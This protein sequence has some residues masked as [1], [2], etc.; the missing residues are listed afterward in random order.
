MISNLNRLTASFKTLGEYPKDAVMSATTD[1]VLG[2]GLTTPTKKTHHHGLTGSYRATTVGRTLIVN[3]RRN[4]HIDWEAFKHTLDV[5]LAHHMAYQF[6]HD[7]QLTISYIFGQK[8][9]EDYRLAM[10]EGLVSTGTGDFKEVVLATWSMVLGDYLYWKTTA[11]LYMEAMEEATDDLKMSIY[12]QKAKV[13]FTHA[14][15]IKLGFDTAFPM[16][17]ITE[18]WL[19]TA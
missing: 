19:P 10:I 11:N 3:I 1:I 9:W 13:A 15:A 6:N 18:M 16:A 17:S 4:N 2:A 5:E 14:E 12:A 7:D 8:Y